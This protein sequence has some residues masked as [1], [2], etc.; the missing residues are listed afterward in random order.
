MHVA[1]GCVWSMKLGPAVK[2]CDASWTLVDA[3]RAHTRSY[4]RCFAPLLEVTGER[5]RRR[6][7]DRDVSPDLPP[8]GDDDDDEEGAVVPREAT[9]VPPPPMVCRWGAPSE[10]EA[11]EYLPPSALLT[12]LPPRLLAWSVVAAVV[13]RTGEVASGS[14]G[15]LR[16]VTG[17]YV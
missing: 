13:Y 9:P 17:L 15:S 1:R 11:V 6:G 12:P 10:V 4:P 14:S 8:D 16:P 2:Q 3:R 7:G 5:K